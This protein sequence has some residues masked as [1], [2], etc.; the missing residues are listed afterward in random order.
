[1]HDL[2]SEGSGEEAEMAYN[3]TSSSSDNCSDV[4]WS[5]CAST[6]AVLLLLL[7]RGNWR[8]S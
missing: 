1:M 3:S 8:Q 7:F 4:E 2:A 6:L 5:D